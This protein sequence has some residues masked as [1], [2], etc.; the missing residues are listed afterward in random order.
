MAAL[1]SFIRF[2]FGSGHAL[3]LGTATLGLI[4][5]VQIRVCSPVKT[6]ERN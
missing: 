3:A 5:E 6:G 4:D 2:V 1:D